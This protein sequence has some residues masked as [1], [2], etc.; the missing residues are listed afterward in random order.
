MDVRTRG[1]VLVG[2]PGGVYREGYYPAG[3]LVLPGPNR[4][5]RQALSASARHYRPLLGPSH[6]WLLALSMALQDP[7]MGEIPSYIS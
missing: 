7:N 3:I 6:T 4:Y 5:L 1:A 2:V